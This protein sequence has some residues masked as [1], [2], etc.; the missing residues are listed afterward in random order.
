MYICHS[1]LLHLLNIP[2]NFYI[3]TQLSVINQNNYVWHV[4]SVNCVLKYIGVW[5]YCKTY[6]F[7]EDLVST[8][9][10][11]KYNVIFLF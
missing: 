2:A 6:T 1:M 8:L 4:S 7:T 3:L 9:A 10:E 5:K 11:F